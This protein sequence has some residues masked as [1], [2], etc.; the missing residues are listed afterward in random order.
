[1]ANSEKQTIVVIGAGIIGVT[2]ALILLETLPRQQ[3]H[4]LLAS[5]YFSTDDGPNPSYPTTL[6]GAHYR[7]IPATTPQLKH[8]ARLAKAT[9]NRFKALAAAHPE[10]GVEFMEGIDYVSGQATPTYKALL[11]DYVE[12]DGFRVLDA[13]EVPE[14]VEFGAR[15]EAFCVDPE[16]YMMHMLRRFKIGG[17]E[18]RRMRL[19]SV[20]EG[21]EIKGRHGR[22][23]MV[24]NCTGVGIDDP[25][26]FII[27]GQTCLV[28]NYC[29][30]TITKQNADGTWSFLVPRPLNGG[31][32]VGGTKQPNDW[33]PEPSPAVR[34]QLLQNAANLY[35][36][37]LNKDGQFEVV[38]DVVGRRPARE[39]GMRLELETLPAGNRK[40]VHAYGLAGRG[41]ELSWGV[42]DEILK[43]VQA[44]LEG[45]VPRSRL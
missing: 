32:I 26:S 17:G 9:Y 37:I 15:Y 33:S 13:S 2:S 22:V 20:E 38:R 24:V 4:I 40:V 21:F 41:V 12:T 36:A 11:P 1:M 10:Y 35:P 23:R 3:Y 28:S 19:K 31:T 14:G 30:K 39:G 7:P 34:N 18:V 5:E 43:M 25:K 27:R 16:V 6:S 29:D 42:A 8:E 45:G 44:E